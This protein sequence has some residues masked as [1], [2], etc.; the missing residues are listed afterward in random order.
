LINY[1][2]VMKIKF[3]IND[4]SHFSSNLESLHCKLEGINKNKTKCKRH[5]VIGSPYCFTHLQ[6]EKN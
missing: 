2:N 3:Y 4:Q 1:I 6:S 5:V